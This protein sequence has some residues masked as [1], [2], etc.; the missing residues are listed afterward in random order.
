MSIETIIDGLLEREGEAFTDDPND[1]GHATKW[2]ITQRTLSAFLGRPATVEEVKALPREGASVIY[3]KCYVIDPG[4]AGVAE[5]SEVIATELV[6][7]G[8]NCGQSVAATFL[9]RIL[10]AFNQNG[11]LYP[12][13]K[14]DGDCGPTTR[15]AL[16]AYL[17]ARRTEGEMVL[18]VSLNGLQLERY[19][20]IAE[21][22]ESQEKFV[23]GQVR[24]RVVVR[25]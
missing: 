14:L 22:D 13:L 18:L 11:A 21:K 10:N 1:R 2:G 9:Q 25:G 6:D 15:A 19:I 5:L 3:R 7:T 16:R 20:E 12:N 23:Y 24:A 17:A 4:F 8:V